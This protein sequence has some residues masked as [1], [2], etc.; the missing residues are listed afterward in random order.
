MAKAPRIRRLPA[1]IGLVV[2]LLALLWISWIPAQVKLADVYWN[3]LLDGGLVK[4]SRYIGPHFWAV[5]FSPDGRRLALGGMSQDVLLF[6]LPSGKP[7]PS[8]Y[9]HSEWVMEVLWS[10]DG[11][12][13]ASTSFSGEVVVQEDSTGAVIYRSSGRD[14]AYTVA[15]HPSEPVLAW[16]AYDGSLRFVD[17]A[18]GTEIRTLRAH[19][20]GVLYV[21][22]TPDGRQIAS[23]GEDGTIRLWDAATLKPTQALEGHEAGITAVSFS[24][25]G[26]LAVS[27]GDDSTVRLWSP[28]DGRSLR[29]ESPHRG[30]I[31]FSTFLPGQDRYLTVGTDDRV[32]VWTTDADSAP[33]KLAEHDDWLMCVRPS[34]DGAHFA[35]TGKDGTAR[36]W[37]SESLEVVQVLDIWETIDP[38]GLRWPAL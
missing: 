4:P 7:L 5:S 33:I 16:G 31:N 32:F 22:W 19:E 1:A 17:L 29:V 23:T 18:T 20:G 21:T 12:W 15:F 28:S 37:N 6:E 25:D 10:S 2:G 8:P 3:I 26:G 11:R 34:A 38:G 35:T 24:A 36:I 30:W 13:F 14:V 27:G 9:R